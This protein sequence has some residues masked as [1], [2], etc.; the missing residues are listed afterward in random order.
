VNKQAQCDPSPQ[1]APGRRLGGS[2]CPAS[3][4]ILRLRL[5]MTFWGV[6]AK[7]FRS[8][9]KGTAIVDGRSAFLAGE[10]GKECVRCF[11][12]F[13]V[14]RFG[15]FQSLFQKSHTRHAHQ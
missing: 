3:R 4:E 1:P 8:R 10:P 9:V 2:G 7:R 14:A 5:Q 15:F 11:D 13:F 6:E 12:V